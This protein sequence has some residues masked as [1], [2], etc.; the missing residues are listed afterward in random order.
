MPVVVVMTEKLTSVPLAIPCEVRSTV[1]PAS[2]N[3]TAIPSLTPVPLTSMPVANDEVSAIVM[4]GE[5]IVV[6]DDA[7]DIAVGEPTLEVTVTVWAEEMPRLSKIVSIAVFESLH[8][9]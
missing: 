7:L 3:V 8:E 1:S 5:F 4:V 6:P 2:V 9:A